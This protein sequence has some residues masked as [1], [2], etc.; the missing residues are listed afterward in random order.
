MVWG[1]IGST[2]LTA[3][4]EDIDITTTHNIFSTVLANHIKNTGNIA[5]AL[6]FNDD[7][8]SVYVRRYSTDGGSDTTA[9]EPNLFTDTVG[10]G[11]QWF[12]VTF[13]ANTASKE[14]LVINNT[15]YDR[16]GGVKRQQM[17]GK[18][19]N[20]SSAIT[21]IS[22]DRA[23]SA[24]TFASG[25]NVTALGSDITPAPTVPAIPALLPSLPS[26]SV[27][28]WKLL[29]RATSSSS[30]Q[31]ITATGTFDKEYLMVLGNSRGF[32][33][34]A[35]Q[36]IRVGTA[37]SV[38]GNQNYTYRHNLN[39]SSSD[40]E[41]AQAEH[42]IVAG[43]STTNPRFSV[44]YITNTLNQQKL[45]TGHGVNRRNAGVGNMPELS[46]SAGKYVNNSLINAVGTFSS[47][48]NQLAGT[49]GGDPEVIVLGW[50]PDDTHTDNFWEELTSKTQTGGNVATF[51]TD[52]FSAKKY[53]WIQAYFKHGTSDNIGN[54]LFVNGDTTQK[55]SQV[56]C[57]NG[58]SGA[59]GANQ[60]QWYCNGFVTGEDYFVNT[61]I[62]N[63]DGDEKI[64][65]QQVTTDNG[66]N[67]VPNR[68]QMGVKYTVT[69]GQIT[70]VGIKNR[71]SNTASRSADGSWIK[72]WGAD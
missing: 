41:L 6:T 55:Y 51:E 54:D 33:G 40:D 7:T 60:Y 32:S 26:G 67:G 42:W 17:V 57:N 52:E 53:L 25:T 47:S 70:K 43:G 1:K 30:T 72:V 16:D 20:T 8:S 48:G 4:A 50:D 10:T 66:G 56:Y 63:I 15:C 44:N 46:Q 37:G 58:A 39:G 21:K 71:G 45:E 61:F 68:R 22:W 18:W 2:T 35:N 23:N 65:I 14:K 5:P 19:V 36:Y 49:N 62:L 24:G 11:T 9:T 69:S 31:L 27:G 12:N 3:N 64:G 38:D 59:S 28:G 13:I 29:G 34:N